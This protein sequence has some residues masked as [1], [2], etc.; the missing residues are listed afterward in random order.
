VR[1]LS[2][3]AY[4]YGINLLPI[5]RVADEVM[6]FNARLAREVLEDGTTS[7]LD[8]LD[9]RFHPLLKQPEDSGVC[10]RGEGLPPVVT[11]AQWLRAQWPPSNGWRGMRNGGHSLRGGCPRLRVGHGSGSR[12]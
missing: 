2:S 10:R 11:K 7:T 8:D 3:P 9:Q 5:E 4:A 12:Q 1:L 6:R